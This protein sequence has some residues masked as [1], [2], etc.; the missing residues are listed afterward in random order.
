MR[1]LAYIIELLVLAFMVT[2]IVR[3][4]MQPHVDVVKI[5]Q[6]ADSTSATNLDKLNSLDYLDKFDKDST[7]VDSTSIDSI[8]K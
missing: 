7:A 6:E 5:K 1:I 2:A 4:N 8:R 3:I